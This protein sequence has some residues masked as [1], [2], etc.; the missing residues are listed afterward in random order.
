[1]HETPQPR[2]SLVPGE[3]DQVRRL[4]RFRAEHPDVEVRPGEF[5]TWQ[6]SIPGPS[7]EIFLTR[8]RLV[9]LLNK[10]DEMLPV[11]DHVMRWQELHEQYP[12]AGYTAPALRFPWYAGA[13]RDDD[14]VM[15]AENLGAL[16]DRLLAREAG[17]GCR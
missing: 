6:A 11:S 13:L 15:R 4:Q 9:E 12:E 16:I 8:H 17:E 10:L 5:G 14:D 2:L 1:M 3:P 7:A